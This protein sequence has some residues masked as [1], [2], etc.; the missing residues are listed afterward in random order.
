MAIYRCPADPSTVQTRAGVKLNQPRLR[1]YNLSQSINGLS[2]DG[3]LANYI[4]HFSKFAQIRN[5]MPTDLLLF[6][7]VHEDEILDTEFGIPVET[8]WWSEGYWW[9]IPAN[10]HN[11]GCNLS[12]ADGHVEHW[13]WKVAQDC[14]GPARLGTGRCPQ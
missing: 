4:P 1:S 13:K 10:R 2:F 6:I 9:D 12:F 14:H 8:E 3:D 5:P 11:Q 7:D